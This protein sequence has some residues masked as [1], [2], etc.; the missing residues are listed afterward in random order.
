MCL[1]IICDEMDWPD[2]QDITTPLVVLLADSRVCTGALSLVR[3]LRKSS[4][5]MNTYP[6]SMPPIRSTAT[7]SD[8]VTSTSILLSWGSFD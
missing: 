6:R 8:T 4:S 1:V 7:H 5:S 3:P 2:V